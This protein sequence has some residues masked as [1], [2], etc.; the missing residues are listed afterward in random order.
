MKPFD[1]IGRFFRDIW[2]VFSVEVRRIFTDTGVMLVFFVAGLSY[3]IFF[4]LVYHS[5]A[6]NDLPVAV[7][8]E[9]QGKV[10]RRFT[11][12]VNATPELNVAYKCSTM[13]EA[14]QLMVDRKING[15]IYFPH[16][17]DEKLNRQETGR[18]GVFCDMST[19]LYYKSVV[20]GTNYVMLDE[21]KNIQLDRYEMTGTEG[22]LAQVMAKPVNYDDVKLYGCG[23]GG[24][25]SFLIPALLVLVIHQ[26]LFFGIGM[27][28][29]GAREDKIEVRL[30]PAHLRNRSVY[31]VVLGRALAYLV[32]YMPLVVVDILLIPSIFNLPHL[33]SLKDL[34]DFFI[35]FLLATVFFGMTASVLVKERETGLLTMVFFSIILLFLSGFAWPRENFP[36]VWR[37][38]SY[39]FPSTFGIQGF[40][41]LNSMGAQLPQ[42]A[43]EYGALWVQAGV[44][45]VG[46]CAAMTY[47]NKKRPLHEKASARREQNQ[48]RLKERVATIKER[49][50]QAGA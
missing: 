19:F 43:A 8:D 24:F 39:I 25:V 42:V 11:H 50:E 14:K 30:M 18:V 44:Y 32:V 22:E 5:E 40:I 46:A 16:D 29:G 13:A 35:P 1:K 38:F 33:A 9:S 45:F 20:M 23:T 2:F 37:I 3:P 34:I 15:I 47:V 26:T 31:R 12:K 17:F 21:L 41:R 10:S 28:G 48:A 4:N 7:V 6:V 49:R 27:L 36:W